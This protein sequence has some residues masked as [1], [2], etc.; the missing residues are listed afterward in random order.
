M[1]RSRRC[2]AL[3]AVLVPALA[4]AQPGDPG[5]PPPPGP[6][7]EPA[8]PPTVAPSPHDA[9][10][11]R[12]HEIEAA[13]NRAADTDTRTNLLLS[14]PDCS[15]PGVVLPPAPPTCGAGQQ[16]LDGACVG[17]K[18]E[19]RGTTAELSAGLTWINLGGSSYS[20]LHGGAVNVGVGRFVTH[21]IAMSLRAS[22]SVLVDG[23]EGWIGV[24][25]PNVQGW[26]GKGFV[27]GGIGLGVVI[28][29]GDTCDATSTSGFDL[30][31][32]YLVD[33]SATL[34]FEV[35]S[36]GGLFSSGSLTMASVLIGF[37]SF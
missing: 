22:G 4:H 7:P 25:G 14:L 15:N 1:S 18:D 28:G 10:V 29:C 13:A 5:T 26:F 27:G 35:E 3:L 2:L 9:C 33:R 34:S 20:F 36:L 37:Q 6:A 24:I 11:V 30:R 32:G 23:G 16:L 31:A 21:D 12:R 8:A 17:G 19:V